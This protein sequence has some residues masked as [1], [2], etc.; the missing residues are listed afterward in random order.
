MSGGRTAWIYSFVRLRGVPP[1][2]GCFIPFVALL[3]A[4][5]VPR[6]GITGLFE[7]LVDLERVRCLLV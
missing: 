1:S 7:L 6:V 5:R 2:I 4:F 3:A